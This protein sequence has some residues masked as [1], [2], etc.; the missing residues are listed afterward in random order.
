[1]KNES[2]T[3]KRKEMIHQ[4][5]LKV[6]SRIISEKGAANITFE[7]LSVEADVA[8]K[9]IYNH[10]ENKSVLLEELIYPICEHAKDYLLEKTEKNQIVLDDI[11]DYCIELWKNQSLNAAVLYQITEEDYPQIHEIKDGFLILFKKLLMR[12]EGYNQLDENNITILADT[13]YTTYLPLLGS[14]RSVPDYENAF[15]AG[16]SGMINALNELMK[17]RNN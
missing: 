4:S 11:W 15:K 7:A 8:R 16:M 14:I 6:A 12:V 5:I 9:T 2:R 17:K 13:I 10:F 3:E 1:M